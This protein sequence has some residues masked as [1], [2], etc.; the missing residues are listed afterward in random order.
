MTTVGSRRHS[1]QLNKMCT[2][3]ISAFHS[4]RSRFRDVVPIEPFTSL[5]RTRSSFFLG[6]TVI[7]NS[8]LH[9]MFALSSS[10]RA[11]ENHPRQASS[12]R[13]CSEKRNNLDGDTIDP[14]V[15]LHVCAVCFDRH[16]AGKKTSNVRHLHIAN[17]LTLFW[18]PRFHVIR[19]Q[20]A[21]TCTFAMT[22]VQPNFQSL[23][24]A[25][26]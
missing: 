15:I 9:D 20:Q 3:S 22:G 4:H 14:N 10:C 25:A 26:P 21:S 1:E 12:H 6:D 16:A 8:L 23:Q 17:V 7:S 19:L 24:F 5:S 11:T 2:C 13:S 18:R